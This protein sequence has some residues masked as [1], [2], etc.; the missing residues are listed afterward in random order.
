[1]SDLWQRLGQRKLV[2]WAVAYVAFAFALLQ[3]IDIVASRF[4]WPAGIER[5][6]IVASCVGFF[7]TLVIAWY[8]G[9]RGVQRVTGTEVLI[10]GLLLAV[11][12]GLLWQFSRPSA[13]QESASAAPAR[14]VRASS[15]NSIAVLPFVDMSQARDQAYFSDGLSDEL[16]NM[17]AQLPQLRVIARTSSF[18]FKGKQADVAT[19]A[20]KLDVAHLLEGSVR[21]SG[22]TLRI[23][24]QLIRASDSSQVWSQTY[25]RKL[26]DV[27]K[28]QDEIATAVVDA[29]KVKLLPDQHLGNPYRSDNAE[30][31]DQYLLGKEFYNRTTP[32]DWRK[33]AAAFQRA[34]DLDPGYGAPRAGLAAAE[35]SLAD[36]AGDPVSKQQALDSADLAV[37]KAPQL[38]DAYAAR[39]IIRLS[40]FRNWDGAGTDFEKALRLNP[41]ASAAQLG[42][43]RLLMAL[44]NLP[45]AIV[46][47]RGATKSNPLSNLTWTSLGRALY[48]AG[49]YSAADQALDRAREISSDSTYSRYAAGLNA[50]A[51]GRTREALTTFGSAGD[52]YSLAG[53]AMAEY[54]LGHAR[55]SRQ[56]L[57]DVVEK[58]GKAGAYQIAQAFA[59]RG[60]ADKA[61][62]WLDTALANN[63]GGLSFLKSDPVL[64]RLS[65]DPRFAALLKKMGLPE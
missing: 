13:T 5:G 46:A 27:F 34:I 24:A 54:S 56:A 6:L 48:A 37:A 26:T 20:R 30:A 19:I 42:N 41:A 47:A 3:G 52:V 63:D 7:A 29:L 60:E 55:Q 38:A 23:S 8:H 58:Y 61:F 43:Y 21:K 4:D 15:P 49:N 53:I 35:Y 64:D 12:G 11:G 31:Y 28:V 44:G 14:P 10:L 17:L 39:G 16:L 32:A 36:L 25:D 2:Q 51:Q 33:A 50:L 22:N 57:D 18:S 1:M 40:F 62:E 9:E 45:E 59:W 65:A